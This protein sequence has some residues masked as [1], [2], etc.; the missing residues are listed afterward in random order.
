MTELAIKLSTLAKVLDNIEPDLRKLTRK[1]GIPFPWPEGLVAEL[2]KRK[3]HNK[4]CE[5][6]FK[7]Q[8]PKNT[9][10]TIIRRDFRQRSYGLACKVACQIL[11]VD[12]VELHCKCLLRV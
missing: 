1:A 3:F 2:K 12:F 11:L 10:R 4:K 9:D 8:P 6:T 7:P 5:L